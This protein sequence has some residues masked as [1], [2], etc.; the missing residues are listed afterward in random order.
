[1]IDIGTQLVIL[2]LWGIFSAIVTNY[3]KKTGK[4]LWI[5]EIG[6]LAVFAIIDILNAT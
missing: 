2:V 3:N 6:I 5:I 1:M 4:I